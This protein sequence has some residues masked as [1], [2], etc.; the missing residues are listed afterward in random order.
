MSGWKTLSVDRHFGEDHDLSH[1]KVQA[2][3]RIRISQADFVWA[4]LDCSTKTRCREIPR[5]HPDGRPMPSP[6]RSNDYPMGLPG[7]QGADKKRVDSDNAAAEFILA[8]LQVHQ[9]KGGASGRENPANSIHWLTP[10]E[11]QMFAGGTWWD[12][13]Y[14]ACVF[15]GARRKKQHIRHDVEEILR[16]GDMTCEH[17]HPP[18]EWDPQKGPDG[19]TWLPS[20]EEAE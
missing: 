1:S 2:D 6:L 17:M 14:D 15:Q 9:L 12:Q 7:L 13:Y 18:S 16:W 10:T 20:K 4:A 3:V 8:E 11:I 5:R 19:K